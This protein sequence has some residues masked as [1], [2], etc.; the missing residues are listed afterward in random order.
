MAWVSFWHS[1][2]L[3]RPA[4]DKSKP[5]GAGSIT[6]YPN[7]EPTRVGGYAVARHQD[8]DTHSRGIC[9]GA[10]AEHQKVPRP[11]KVY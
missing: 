5:L 10:R 4:N 8:W 3:A 7:R 1:V 6:P 2:V 11:F 9:C